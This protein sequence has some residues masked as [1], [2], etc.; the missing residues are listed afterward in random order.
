VGEC[1]Q[2]L[3]PSIFKPKKSRHFEVF[4]SHTLTHVILC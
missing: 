2:V 1:V 3:N 4:R